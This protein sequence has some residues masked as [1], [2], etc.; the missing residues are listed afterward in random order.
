MRY[1][2]Q[3]A[4]GTT[5]QRSAFVRIA[6][7]L[8][9][10][11]GLALSAATA[12]AQDSD[13]DDAY[14]IAHS[15]YKQERWQLAAD[16]LGKFLKANPKHP[17][18]GFAR[19][20]LGLSLTRLN[21]HKSARKELLQFLEENP[22]HL[23][24]PDA[25]FR[26]AECSL[27]QSDFRTAS[28][29]FAVFLINHKK[30]ELA[31][32]A[33]AYLGEA[34]LHLKN[35]RGAAKTFEEALKTYPKGRLIDDLRFGLAQAYEALERPADAIEQF[36]LVT[37]HL[38]SPLADRAHFRLGSLYFGTADYEK[39]IASFEELERLFP[40]SPSLPQGRLIAGYA[41]YKRQE[42]ADAIVRF[43]AAAKT[44]S[45]TATATYWKALSLKGLNKQDEAS[46]ILKSLHAGTSDPEV[47]KNILYQWADAEFRADRMDAAQTLFEQFI[48]RWP[49]GDLAGDSL[50]MAALAAFRQQKTAKA[51]ELGARFE[52]D[53]AKHSRRFETQLLLARMDEAAATN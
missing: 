45:Q 14:R 50:Y 7:A 27:L 37:A 31:E 46:A 10:G 8:V 1:Q 19:L 22:K 47:A 16:A 24:V 23:N 25:T 43:D 2:N 41:H 34:Q 51:G 9:V 6:V 39:S 26:A 11:I 42:F 20:S 33:H 21:Q 40:K 12:I 13:A 53:F 48:Q 36:K 32:W 15:L 30:H 4:E 49:Q 17:K 28:I 38:A 18:A 3:T 5:F 44:E 29:E 52:R 35:A